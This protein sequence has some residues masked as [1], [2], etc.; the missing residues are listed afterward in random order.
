MVKN[1]QKRFIFFCVIIIASILIIL[2]TIVYIGPTSNL[3]IHKLLATIVIG[4]LMTVIGSFIISKIAI[5]PIKQ[6]WQKQLNFTADA[7]HEL[8]TP[9]AVIQTNIEL[10]MDNPE[11]TVESQM[12]WLKNIE[13]E[14]KRMTKL[15]EDLLT[16][17]RADTNEQSLE[18]T[19][20]MLDK[21]IVMA[22]N[23][24]QAVAKQKNI[25]LEININNKIA[26]H[27]DQK[28]IMQLMVILVDNGLYYTNEPGKIIITLSRNEKG[29]IIKVSDTG[30]GIEEEHLDKIFNRFYRVD[31]ARKYN[32]DGSG[33]GLSIVKWIVKEHKGKVKVNSEIKKG[34]TFTIQL[35]VT[36]DKK[37][38]N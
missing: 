3:H 5:T 35:P 7:S 11:E 32:P 4:I 20:F 37:P 36:N 10:V 31:D 23:P 25:T 26:F 27:G 15:V 28:R 12:K 8:R 6:A 33:L 34:T 19:E 9:I 18:M 14:N 13:A 17:S 1:L 2:G 30:C 21:T 38:Y 24:L 16:L 22:L 29:A